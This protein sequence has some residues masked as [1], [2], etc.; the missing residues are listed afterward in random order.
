MSESEQ[1]D[2]RRVRAAKNQSL[3]R[4]VN[5]RIE[6]FAK[7]LSTFEELQQRATIDLLCECMDVMC[8]AHLAVTVGEYEAVRGNSNRFLVLPGH[9]VPEVEV[10]VRDEAGYAVVSKLGAGA[11]V[12]EQLDPRR[13]TGKQQPRSRA[14]SPL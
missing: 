10:V 1:L 2:D 3:L 12:A 5:E 7:G 8:T 6:G 11:A 4:E 14:P 9:E 13:E